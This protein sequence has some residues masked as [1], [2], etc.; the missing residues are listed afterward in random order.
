MDNLTTYSIHE[1]ATMLG[2]KSGWV[3]FRI[4][5]GE[6]EGMSIGGRYRVSRAALEKFQ[7][8]KAKALRDDIENKR[9]NY[10]RKE[11][12]NKSTQFQPNGNG[13]A[14]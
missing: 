11:W 4:R 10:A 3:R 14:V 13:V 2:V 12:G 1:I 6:L 7:A 8:E 5:T 9:G